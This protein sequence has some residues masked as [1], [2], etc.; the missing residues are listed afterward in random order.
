MCY[1]TKP[2]AFLAI[3]EL[4]TKLETCHVCGAKLHLE[5]V[6]PAFCENCS[7]YCEDHDEPAC[8]PF[9]QLFNKARA[10]LFFLKKEHELDI[11]LETL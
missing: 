3:D 11:V 10:A 7:S 4:L 6:E 9:Y 1:I 2:E 8:I 5:D